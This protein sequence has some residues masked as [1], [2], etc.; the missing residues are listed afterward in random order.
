LIADSLTAAG[1]GPLAETGPLADLR[2]QAHA[3]GF[4]LAALDVRQHSRVHEAA[5]ADL[6]ARAGVAADYAALS[7][8]ERLAILEAELA[9]PR[10]L[11]RE[12][13]DLGPDAAA[14]LGAYRA[15]RDAYA[16]EPEALG[17]FIV[18]MTDSVSD[19]LEVLLLAHEAGLWTQD[20]DG[21]VISPVDAVPL[22]ETISDLEAAP[23]ILGALFASPAYRRHLAA[24]GGFQEV[25]LGYS[26]SNK[27]GGYWA[28]NAA[29][30]TAQRA[31][32]VACREAGVALRLFHGR[33]GTV[34][35]GGGRAGGAILGMPAEAQSGRIRFTEQ[36]ETIS[37][38]YAL[39]GIAHRH[40]EQIV[41]AQTVALCDAA[42]PAD[43]DPASNA[44]WQAVAARSMEAYRALVDAP[45]FWAWFRA[46]TPIEAIAGLSIASRPVSRGGAM[47]LDSLRAIP[48]GFAWTQPRM[49]VPG[50]FGAGT[51]LAAAFSDGHLDALRAAYDASPFLRAV[52]ENAMREMARARLDIAR[53]YAHRAEALDADG[54]LFERVEAEFARTERALLRLA[55]RDTLLPEG[56]SIAA[57]IRYRNPPTDVLNLVQIELMTRMHADPADDG[58]RAALLATLN[59]LAA[60]MQSTG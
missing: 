47:G 8:P 36:G 44:H 26:D 13:A 12:G 56:S 38:R 48:W 37:F 58:A 43:P 42:R 40:L 6:L 41:H 22:F 5:V 14:A 7:E 25:M 3:F 35:R 55:R 4:H 59:A 16:A 33:G 50:W 11:V 57:T 30:H 15:A 29:L 1:L 24:R 2:V 20:T 51:A 18:S 34:G 17:A 54:A 10:P 28:A 31:V 39:P 23:G 46:V 32:A 53:R 9:S 49:T 60:A 27:D 45:G 52:A 19:L 21:T